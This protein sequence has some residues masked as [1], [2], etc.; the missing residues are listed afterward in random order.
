MQKFV[1]FERIIVY[2]KY[3]D[4]E[5]D[6]KTKCE[7]K[8][9]FFKRVL[10]S[11]PLCYALNHIEM[12]QKQYYIFAADG[13]GSCVCVDSETVEIETVWDAPGGTMSIV[14]LPGTNGDFL[15]SQK[16]L[17]VFAAKHSRIVRAH[18]HNGWHV[19]PVLDVPY[20]H[21]FDLVG[22]E[23]KKWII[24]CILS[25]TDEETVQWEVPGSVKIIEMNDAYEPVGQC[26]TIAENMHRNH[27]FFHG[28]VQGEEW[29]LV[30]CDE[31]VFRIYPNDDPQL[32][33]IEQLIDEPCSDITV[34]DL[35]G[36]GQAEIIAISPFHGEA[37]SVYEHDGNTYQKKW[38]C[39]HDSSF[40]H[41]IW[42]GMLCG[43][44]VAVIGGRAGRRQ[45][46]LLRYEAGSYRAEQIE[47]GCGLSNLIVCDDNLIL[48]NREIG[49]MAVIHCTNR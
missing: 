29:L 14:P 10:G 2:S 37:L 18:R 16:F 26:H 11:L 44:T 9:E 25:D 32:W 30:S 41:G 48:A 22:T 40:L 35:N 7:V 3:V 27:G 36:D 19:E 12:D 21:R 20:V 31:G 24:L 1:A 33:R 45:T 49:E 8:M 13:A 47:E 6:C 42:S 34:C 38:I 15:A 46:L 23:T 17:P 39:R 5:I 28:M 4:I 43:E